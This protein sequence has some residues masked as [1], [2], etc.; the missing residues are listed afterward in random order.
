MQRLDETTAR[1]EVSESVLLMI[2]KAILSPVIQYRRRLV[3][4]VDLTK[5]PF[6]SQWESGQRVIVLG[7]D[8]VKREMTAELRHFLGGEAA[9]ELDGVAGGDRL[10]VVACQTEYLAYSY[11]FFATR[12]ASRRQAYILGET[13]NTPIIGQSFTAREARGRGIYRRVLSEMFMYLRGAGYERAICEVDP[14]NHPSIHAS[15]AAGMRVC[16]EL[17]DWR[18]LRRILVQRVQESGR[19]GWRLCWVP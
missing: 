18:I 19:I 14:Q 17:D 1:D 11:I 8:N 13:G 16:R 4:E 15:R 10:F 5:E 2:G 7:P 6:L 9:D 12:K 3:W